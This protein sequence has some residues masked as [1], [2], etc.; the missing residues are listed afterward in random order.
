MADAIPPDLLKKNKKDDLY[1]YKGYTTRLLLEWKDAN[2]GKVP[3]TEEQLAILRSGAKE[4]VV[5]RP[6]YT[7]GDVTKKAYQMLPMPRDFSSQASAVFSRKTGRQPTQ[8][9][10]LDL[11]SK[12]KEAFGK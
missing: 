12:Q 9:E 6:W 3:T 7:G 8:Q 1:A 11:W 4:Y 10:L 5:D 2:P